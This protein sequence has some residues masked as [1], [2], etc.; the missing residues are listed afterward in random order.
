MK[1]IIFALILVVLDQLSKF[2]IT[3]KNIQIFQGFSLKFVTNTGAA[4]SLFQGFNILLAI[5]TL[6]VIAYLAIQLRKEKNKIRMWSFILIISGGMGNLI[7]RIFLGHVRDF[8]MIWIWPAFNFADTFITI[9]AI[10]LIY[11][12]FKN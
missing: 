11:S 12:Y 6:A 3:S 8:I 9:G 4:F 1:K 7:D 10:L 2:L 5:L